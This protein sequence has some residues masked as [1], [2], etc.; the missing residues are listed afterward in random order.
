MRLRWIKTSID[1]L[2]LLFGIWLR[3]V[4]SVSR[5]KYFFLNGWSS[6]LSKWLYSL[7]VTMVTKTDMTFSSSS[8]FFLCFFLSG[9][10]VFPS[11][12]YKYDIQFHFKRTQN[13]NLFF[14]TFFPVSLLQYVKDR[15]IGSFYFFMIIHVYLLIFGFVKDYSRPFTSYTYICIYQ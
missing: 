4:R 7:W 14:S 8:I 5:I 3:G 11:Y 12:W 13:N 10:F 9:M 6:C 2:L 15:N 1:I